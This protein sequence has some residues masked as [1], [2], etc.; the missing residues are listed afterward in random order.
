MAEG[1]GRA[2]GI[3]REELHPQPPFLCTYV[4]QRKRVPCP[5]SLDSHLFLSKMERRLIYC[6]TVMKGFFV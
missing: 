1:L 2:L 4:E 6:K 5:E 3:P